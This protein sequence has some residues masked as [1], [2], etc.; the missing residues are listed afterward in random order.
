MCRVIILTG[1][2]AVGKSTVCRRAAILA[3][4]RGYTCCGIVTL[5]QQGVR[6]VLDVGSGQRRR[7]TRSARPAHVHAVNEAVTQ[8]RFRF[9]PETLSWGNTVLSQA[10]PCDLLVVDEVGPLEMERGQGFVTA[11][12]TLQAGRY[13]LALLVVRPELLAQ[14]CDR[15]NA[16]AL[17]VLA[18]TRE[19]RDRLPFSLVEMVER[20]T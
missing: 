10:G 14:A 15:L 11:F 4:G 5:A 1:E 9:N 20:E 3:Q 12:D 2:R 17:E 19:N 7:L 18:V 6:D 8:G 13:R 16:C